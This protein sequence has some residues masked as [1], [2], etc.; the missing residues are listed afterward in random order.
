MLV[1]YFNR[2]LNFYFVLVFVNFLCSCCPVLPSVVN[3]FNL[4]I[5]ECEH[6]NI[7]NS[8]PFSQCSH[9]DKIFLCKIS[10]VNFA[11][12]WQTLFQSNLEDGKAGQSINCEFLKRTKHWLTQCSKVEQVLI[13]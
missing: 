9:P 2:K 11:G 8:S 13:N 7:N 3:H 1:R 12:I 6:L 4:N 5:L 10:T